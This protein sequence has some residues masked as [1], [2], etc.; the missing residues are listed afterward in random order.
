[1]KKVFLFLMC[2][3][4]LTSFST[5]PLRV[6]FIGDSLTCYTGGWQDQVCR[7]FGY[8]SVNRS[9]GG[10]IT[11]W[12]RL[13]LNEHLKRDSAFTYCFIY[14]G[15]NDAYSYVNLQGAVNN[16][17]MMVDSCNRRG[18]KPIVIVGYDPAKVSIKTVYDAATTKR[19]RERYVEF[20]K[21]MVHPETGLKNCKIIPKDTTVTFQDAGDG[22]HLGGNGQRK[23]ANWVI[24]HLNQ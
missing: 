16:I 3:V 21:L 17:Q 6:L 8:Q 23:F 4:L 24:N 5:P 7:Y 22:I 14:G 9:V 13:T 20:Q 18:I 2:F 19:C 1:M 12:M 10:K 11:E 15:C